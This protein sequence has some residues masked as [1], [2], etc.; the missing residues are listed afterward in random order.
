MN[1][2]E[3][4]KKI[5]E[6]HSKI[7]MYG[8]P[9]YITGKLYRFQPSFSLIDFKLSIDI[10]SEEETNKLTK[11]LE[12][13]GLILNHSEDRIKIKNYF[14]LLKKIFEKYN[15]FVEDYQYKSIDSNGT[16]DFKITNK[17]GTCFFIEVK[18]GDNPGISINQ[19]SWMAKHREEVWYLIFEDSNLLL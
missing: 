15:L 16:P 11:K 10:L 7:G 2:E 1:T 8:S 19:L 14:F 4:L 9:V 12:E 3:I 13:C 18:K 17:D 5:T 6:E